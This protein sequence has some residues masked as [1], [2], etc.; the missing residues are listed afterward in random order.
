MNRRR[1]FPL[2]AVVFAAALL[3]VGARNAP[4]ATV[5]LQDG[6]FANADWTVTT[7][8]LNLGGS[9]SGT[10][11]ATGGN[12]GSYRQVTNTTNSAI[13]QPFSNT[14]FGFHRFSGGVYV[15]STGG[16]ILT[17]DFSAATDR[18]T[19]G[20]QAYGLALRQGGVIYYGPLFLNPTAFNT[21][22]T[23]TQ[24]G[25]TA[26]SFDALAPGVQNPNF[27]VSGSS[28]EFGFVSGNS[29]SVGGGGGTTVGGIDN[30]TA[31]LHTDEATPAT[32]TSWGRVKSLYSK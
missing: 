31:T 6:T 12:P 7:E 14:V 21:W 22:A 18:I 4:A 10:Q 16:A 8:V 26:A 1:P 3:P 29:T 9:A 27:S 5:V 30:W 17:V 19:S 25:L 32:R 15:P 24:P 11:T 20:Q 23:T 28:I 13:G 2:L